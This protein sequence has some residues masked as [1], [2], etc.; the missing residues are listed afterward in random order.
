[1]QTPWNSRERM[2]FSNNS[3]M[4]EFTDTTFQEQSKKT[5]KSTRMEV[6]QFGKGIHNI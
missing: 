6:V 4:E 2:L 5:N 1:M 3:L